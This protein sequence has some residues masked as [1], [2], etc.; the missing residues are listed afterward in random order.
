MTRLGLP[1]PYD[2]HTI[3]ANNLVLLGQ[4]PEPGVPLVV[5]DNKTN[6]GNSDWLDQLLR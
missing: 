3:A 4:F 2:A 6:N 5:I 1:I